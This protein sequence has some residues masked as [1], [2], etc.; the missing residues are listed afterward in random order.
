M[1]YDGT[2]KFDTSLDANGFQ[3]GANKLGSI[4]KGLSVFKVLSA[5]VDM[6]KNSVDAAF[7]R[8]DTMEQFGRVMNTMTGDVEETNKALEKAK[9]IVTGTGYGLDTAAKS[10]QGFVSRGMEVSKATKTLERFGDAVAFFEGGTN[11]ALSS[12]MDALGKMQTKGNVTMEHLE[13]L[14]NA[15]I[16]AVQIY[17]S[18]VGMSTDEVTKAM[19]KGQLKTDDFINTLNK[20]FQTGVEGFPS[21][22]GAAKEAGASWTGTFD[23]MKAAITRGTQAIITNIDKALESVGKPSLRESIANFGKTFENVLKGIAGAAGPIVKYLDLIAFGVSAVGVA[24]MGLKVGKVMTDIARSFQETAVQVALYAMSVNGAV[25][26]EAIQIASLSTKEV[27]VGVLTKKIGFVTAVQWAWNA[28]MNANPIGLVIAGIGACVVAAVGLTVA[29]N[30]NSAAYEK[31][32]QEVQALADAHEQLK[33]SMEDSQETYEKETTDMTASAIAGGDLYNSLVRLNNIENKSDADKKKMALTV[34]QLNGMYSGLNL[35]YNE[36]NDLLNQNLNTV[37]DYI[38]AQ[39]LISEVSSKEERHNELLQEQSQIQA[40]LNNLYAEKDANRKLWLSG[41]ITEKEYQNLVTKTS[42]T[43]TE[44]LTSLEEKTNQ[45]SAL[46]ADMAKSNTDKAKKITENYDWLNTTMTKNGQTAKELADEWGISGEQIK[47]LCDELNV[48]SLDELVKT[49]EENTKEW[50][51]SFESHKDAIVNSFEKIPTKFKLSADQMTQILKDNTA[52]YSKWQENI[53]KLSGIM[54]AEA[55]AE[56]EK[57]GPAANSAIEEY[58]KNADKAK[59]FDDAVQEGIKAAVDSA[60]KDLPR[61]TDT[62]EKAGEYIGEGIS[63]SPAIPE[64]VKTQLTEVGKQIDTSM[65]ELADNVDTTKLSAAMESGIETGIKNGTKSILTVFAGLKEGLSGQWDEIS[66]LCVN[67]VTGIML[68]T[69]VGFRVGTDK[70]HDIVKAKLQDIHSTML[71]GGTYAALQLVNG[72]IVGL[73]ANAWRLNAKADQLAQGVISRMNKAFDINSPSRVTEAM[74]RY[75]VMG[76]VKGFDDEKDTLYSKADEINAEI[77]DRLEADPELCA[78]MVDRMRDIASY[79]PW[80]TARLSPALSPAYAGA[81]MQYTSNF[82]Q[83]I[84]S[85]EAL[86]PSEMSQEAVDAQRRLAW[87]IP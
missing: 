2:L 25:T 66:K 71:T 87:K 56:L 8:I 50:Q 75:V 72:M 21:V 78:S 47:T 1:A 23:N 6:V 14:F 76:G 31:A 49:V 80:D 32:A 68:Q 81:G 28:A 58:L 3:K 53:S 62:G 77:L 52:K 33:T 9:N 15:N 60:D 69:Q 35:K 7:G 85:H 46:E 30:K 24:V 4:V 55:I 84:N 65:Q 63:K 26:A 82:T 73:T 79:T 86:S 5:G 38:G 34:Q 12:V 19:S 74:F 61:L 51:E 27:L 45:I 16:P 13:M 29:L 36:E 40:N 64:A 22:A 70:A 59:E 48:Q 43:E 11:A 20:A 10:V 18:A 44:Y 17:A 37:K 39:N 42:K 57:L 67:S 83:I 41:T 54:S